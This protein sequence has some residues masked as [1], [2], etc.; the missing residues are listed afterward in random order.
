M[1]AGDGDHGAG[2]VDARAG[3]EAFVDGAL[4]AEG[5]AAEIADGGEAAE[6]CVAG[7]GGGEEVE[8]A[9]VVGE[10]L[11]RAWG[12]RASRASGRRSGRA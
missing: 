11:R 3:G 9:D 10:G 1:A 7:F 2:G 5:G 6:E 8:V 12:G 4:E